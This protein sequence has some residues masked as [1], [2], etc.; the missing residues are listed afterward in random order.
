MTFFHSSILITVEKH[1][2]SCKEG[3]KVVAIKALEMGYL[4]VPSLNCLGL[5]MA[6]Y[7]HVMSP[8]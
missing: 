6:R 3:S 5:V 2:G 7:G 4:T 8:R 1:V